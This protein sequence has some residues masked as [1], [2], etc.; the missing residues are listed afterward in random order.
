MVHELKASL[1]NCIEGPR[2]HFSDNRKWVELAAVI[3]Y[4]RYLSEIPLGM[5]PHLIVGHCSDPFYH[6]H[7]A[8]PFQAKLHLWRSGSGVDDLWLTQDHDAGYIDAVRWLT[9]GPLFIMDVLQGF[10]C[11]V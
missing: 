7:V 3:Q 2:V 5:W 1:A 8:Q 10:V 6:V 11:L 9:T 4:S